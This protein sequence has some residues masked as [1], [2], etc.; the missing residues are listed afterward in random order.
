MQRPPSAR[1][2]K[3]AAVSIS[4]SQHLSKY[5]LERGSHR[6]PCSSANDTVPHPPQS[7][8]DQLEHLPTK[9]EMLTSG[10]G[11]AGAC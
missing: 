8:H 10:G 1:L 4:A 3:A 9:A 6:Q 11:K 7:E 5:L 2:P